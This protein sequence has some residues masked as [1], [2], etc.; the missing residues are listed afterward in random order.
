MNW[1]HLPN[2]ITATRI[3]MVPP[4][5]WLMREGE[6]RLAF[7]VAL[8]AGGSDALDGALAKGFG[9][10]SRLGGLLDPLADKLLIAAC[11][12]GLWSVG[13]LPAWLLVLVLARDALIVAGAFAYQGLIGPVE[14][15]PTIASKL[16]TAAQIALALGLLTALA[17]PLPWLRPDAPYWKAAHALV[18]MLT[19]LSGLHYIWAWGALAWRQRGGR[20]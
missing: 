12:V 13:A 6:F 4:L 18:A 5:V 11:F 20:N 9:W 16:N 8:V 19:L 2:L 17:W 7:W 15:R 3:A 10:Q 1:R 14:A